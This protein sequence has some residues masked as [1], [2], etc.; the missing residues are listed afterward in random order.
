MKKML[1]T[2][3]AGFIGSEFARQA[4]ERGY[5]LT[6]LD[7][8][9]Y[10]GDRKRLD[11]I[12]G[13]FDFVSGDIRNAGL[14]DALLK[15]GR[16]DYVA[17]F[18]AESHVDRSILD[19]SIF[20]ETNV[21][22]T[23]ALLEAARKHG[24]EKFLHVSTDEVYGD[25]GEDGQF[26]ETTA[27]NPSSPYSASKAAADF[28][29]NSYRRTHGLPVIIVRPSNN[30]GPWQYPE[31][32]IPVVIFKALHNEKIPVYA[33]GLNVREWLFVE[34]CAK[35]MF[36]VLEGGTPGEVYN[37][38]SGE[39]RKNIDVVKTILEIMGKPEDLIEFVKD[40]AGHDFRYSLN[41]D[42]IKDKLGWKAETE[43]RSGIEKTVSW[44]L[45]NMGWVEEKIDYLRNYW[46]GVYQK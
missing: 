9:T 22:G 44:Y 43:F 42:K 2:G 38:G 20:V 7:N 27:L 10:A 4:V 5:E 12:G 1:L 36:S 23:T 17:H 25:L 16:F 41:C 37:L 40:R 26:L 28:L 34:D 33:R 46:T 15:K 35:G 3:G 14:L 8:L 39:E 11:A 13:R 29:A 45:T 30:Y 31:K 21:M 18:A 32:L 19:S 6:V 24:T